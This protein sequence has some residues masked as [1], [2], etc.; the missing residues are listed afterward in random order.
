MRRK[1]F[2]NSILHAT[3]DGKNKKRYDSARP[4]LQP[5]NESQ[6]LMGQFVSAWL[7]ELGL[8]RALAKPR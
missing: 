4:Q 2:A 3:A 5:D 8:K 7:E 1:S 6:Q